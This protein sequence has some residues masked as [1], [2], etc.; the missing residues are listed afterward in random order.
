MMKSAVLVTG[1]L[2]DDDR[3]LFSDFELWKDNE[4]NIRVDKLN[5]V[6]LDSSYLKVSCALLHRDDT[7]I[8]LFNM[9]TFNEY[10]FGQMEIA[11]LSNRSNI[12]LSNKESVKQRISQTKNLSKTVEQR[13]CRKNLSKNN[14]LKKSVE[15]RICQ[16]KNLSN[17][18]SM[19]KNLSN[20]EYAKRR[21]CIAESLSNNLSNKSVKKNL[22]NKESVKR[23]ICRKKN[24][25]NRESVEQRIL[26]KGSVE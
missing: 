9:F 12:Y 2:T 16:A 26:N 17:K 21:I 18:E 14:P 1:A 11:Y 19:G 4:D 10:L 5:F 22:S 24:L 7:S 3:S 20:K 23:R 6:L 15:Q 13:F 8:M 25:S